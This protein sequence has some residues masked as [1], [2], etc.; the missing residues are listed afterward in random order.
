VTSE[1]RR[2]PRL[3]DSVRL[4]Y[5]E[6]RSER[7]PGTEVESF[8][9]NISGG[10][11]CFSSEGA[12]EPGTILAIELALPEFE[13]PVVT[14]GRVSWCEPGADGKHEVG[15]EFWW[16]GWGDENVQRSIGDYIRRALEAD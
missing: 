3:K 14:L 4:R 8:T 6:I 10:G 16:I 7:F 5:R 12:I 13:A 1:R 9:V 2:F 15:T 11:V